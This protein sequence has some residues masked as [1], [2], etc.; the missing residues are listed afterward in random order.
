MGTI[1]RS[2]YFALAHSKLISASNSLRTSKSWRLEILGPTAS[3]V[4]FG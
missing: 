3:V 4:S 1:V 2:S